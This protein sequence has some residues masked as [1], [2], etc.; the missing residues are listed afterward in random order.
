MAEIK[1]K[2]I[3]QRTKTSRF[4]FP[5]LSNTILDFIDSET[6][7]YKRLGKLVDNPLLN[8]YIGDIDKPHY[9]NHIF[10]LYRF[11][12]TKSFGLLEKSLTEHPLYVEMYDPTPNHVMFVFKVPDEYQIEYDLFKSE[13]PKIYRRFSEAYKQHIIKFMEP[14]LGVDDIKSILYSYESGFKALEKKLSFPGS[15]VN[16][17]RDLDN[18]PIPILSEE[19]FNKQYLENIYG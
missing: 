5:M 4:I 9:N 18:Y 10:I 8:A 14:L 19:T 1:D 3:L 7:E 17:P 6:L 16:I 2:I 11:I 15:I 13:K 12:G